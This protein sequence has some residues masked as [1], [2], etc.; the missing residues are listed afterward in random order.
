MSVDLYPMK[1]TINYN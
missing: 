1:Q